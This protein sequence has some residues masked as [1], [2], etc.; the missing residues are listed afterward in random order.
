MLTRH[1][2]P[3]PP[4]QCDPKRAN[5]VAPPRARSSIAFPGDDRGR[6]SPGRLR[7]APALQ[8]ARKP[9]ATASASARWCA[10]PCTRPAPGV[11]G[12]DRR[13]RRLSRRD[14]LKAVAQV[15][16]P[17]SG[18]HAR[19]PGAR[20][21]DGGLL[22]GPARLRHRDHDPGAVRRGMGIKEEKLLALG[23]P[24][25]ARGAGRARAARPAAGPAVRLPGAAVPAAAQGPGAR[26][27]RGIGGHRGRARRARGSLRGR[28]PAG[29]SATPTQDEFAGEL[30]AA[31]PAG[32]QRRAGGGRGGPR[33]R[34]S[35]GPSSGSGSCTGSPGRARRRSTCGDRPGAAGGRRRHP[36]WCRRWR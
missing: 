16:Y 24:L 35:R 30:V 17:V 34:R 2:F 15:V 9:C 23:R 12:V 13:P 33:R 28:T 3:G 22:R 25:I 29:W 31:Q 18:P 11:V 27:A 7:Q 36:C 21:L 1:C 6:P 8:G 32:A 20:P 26:A 19:P 5:G 4:C 14:R 10:S